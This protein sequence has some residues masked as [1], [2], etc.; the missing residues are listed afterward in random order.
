VEYL[1]ENGRKDP[2][3]YT[4]FVNVYLKSTVGKGYDAALINNPVSKVFPKDNEALVLWYLENSGEVWADMQRT[5]NTKKSS[6][7]KR[8]T[9]SGDKGGGQKL[10]GW[11]ELGK[12]QYNE[13]YRI[14][15]KDRTSEE[16]IAFDIHYAKTREK[17][18]EGKNA[19]HRKTKDTPI[20]EQGTFTALNSLSSLA[21]FGERAA[22]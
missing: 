4:W 20:T 17:D 19:K 7:P 9:V 5:G 2:Q 1:V 10:A 8:Y 15:E 14:I 6:V 21:G 13:L 3:A 12:I 11:S 16:G 18:R 22:I